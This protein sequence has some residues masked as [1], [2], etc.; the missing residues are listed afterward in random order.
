MVVLLWGYPICTKELWISFI[1]SIGY[2]V[3][4]LTKALCPLILSL[5]GRQDLGR[6]L[7]PNLFHLR[8][9]E[10]TVL[11]GTLNAAEM[12]LYPFPDLCL[13][14]IV[15]Q[16]YRQFSW[17]HGL[18][19]NLTYTIDCETLYKQV[20][21]FPNYVQW[22]QLGTGGL[23]SRCRSISWPLIEA[24]CTRSVITKGLNTCVFALSLW[25]IVCRFIR[26]K[27]ELNPF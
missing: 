21:A 11:L 17:P 15:S 25:S 20:C 5:A 16:V 19:F 12:F 7:D 13:D 18:A 8:M 4:C 22:I 3:T 6:L 9:M 24:G 27:G 10:A 23:Q 26:E 2:L 14:T 1:V